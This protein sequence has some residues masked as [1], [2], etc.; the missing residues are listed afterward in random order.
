VYSNRKI[1]PGFA[2]WDQNYEK[3][4]HVGKSMNIHAVKL[5]DIAR[6]YDKKLRPK[7]QEF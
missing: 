7:P 5:R 6:F 4:S 2:N 3:I 1:P